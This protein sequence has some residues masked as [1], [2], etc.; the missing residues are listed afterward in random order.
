MSNTYNFEQFKTTIFPNINDE[1]REATVE[2]AS[3][4][5]DLINRVNSLCDTLASIEFDTT[6][7]ISFT[8]N[9]NITESDIT[10][11]NLFNSFASFT[12]YLVNNVLDKNLVITLIGNSSGQD[13]LN[14]LDVNLESVS[15]I[16]FQSATEQANLL[17]SS[18]NSAYFISNLNYPVI[19]KFVNLSFS[20]QKS[21]QFRDFSQL[22]L[23]QC[24]FID[25]AGF[26]GN[27]ITLLNIKHVNIKD[28]YISN[29]E[30]NG[31]GKAIFS[32]LIETLS[33]ESL[34]VRTRTRPL[35]ELRGGNITLD[36]KFNFIDFDY[37]LESNLFILR[38]N[39][40][41]L[42]RNSNLLIQNFTLI[43]AKIFS[44]A[45][46]DNIVHS[47]YFYF[48]SISDVT[49]P[50]IIF[51][52]KPF[53]LRRMY[54]SQVN[55]SASIALYKNDVETIRLTGGS[56]EASYSQ[57][58]EVNYFNAALNNV[59]KL[60]VTGTANNLTLQIDCLYQ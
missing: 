37:T 24:S 13:L 43:N 35:L 5:S 15:Q 52:N 16:T 38:D 20:L 7:I 53:R 59:L 30:N 48:T 31:S 33:I 41:I 23:E 3:N 47:L 26:S 29:I 32:N 21:F 56:Q 46:T 55:S 25:V 8:I 58:S 19:L 27:I 28:C 2:Q 12:N 10:E 40:L 1:P 45:K 51:P 18:N 11:A 9:F 42:E 54:S 57:S 22:E 44:I 34:T 49:V 36:G 17:Y 14:F 50:L 4:G 6:E 39:N 60:K